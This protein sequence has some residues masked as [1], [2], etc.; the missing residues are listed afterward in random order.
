MIWEGVFFKAVESR[1][2]FL[3]ETLFP[4]ANVAFRRLNVFRA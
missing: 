3:C 4:L 2:R 1:D